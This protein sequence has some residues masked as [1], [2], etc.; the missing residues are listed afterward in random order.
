MPA[1]EAAAL[2]LTEPPAEQVQPARRPK[3]RVL[4]ITITFHPEPGAL[5]GLPLARRLVA[6]G[7]ADVTVLTAVPWYPLGRTYPGY[8]Q[9][10]WQWE[11]IDGVRI[12][13]VPIYP[14]HDSSAVRR[15]CTYLSF[16]ITAMTIGIPLAGR[17]DVVYHV[18]NL[19]T[20]GLVALLYGWLRGAPVVQ[21]VGDL[22]PESVTESGMLP[23]N[24]L[25]RFIAGALT[26]LCAFVYRRNAHI[27]VLSAGFERNLLARGL[28]RERVEV[29]HNWA[30]EERFHP[31]PPDPHL[32]EQLGMAG[33]FNV[34]YAGNIGP[35]QAIET[36]VRA[37]ALIRDLPG[38][39]I[40]IIG[41]GPR[42]SAVRALADELGTTNVCFLG[43]RPL[44]EMN[45][46]NAL[47][48]VLLVH[49]ADREFLRSTV[50]SKFQVAL[51]SAKPILLGVR[52]DAADLLRDAAAGVAFAPEN[53]EELA[54][55]IRALAM[56]PR[57]ELIAM[58]QRGKAYYDRSLSADQG[59]R[60]M[61]EIFRATVS[62]T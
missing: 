11:V 56:L 20:T 36:V 26:K 34:V 60:R 49:L 8:R 47:S 18:D 42:M 37:G 61:A 57:D 32:A 14:S 6:A 33:Y 48:D 28:S 41:D 24:G 31:T 50:P 27:T 52:G 45:D 21:H 35:L 13:R 2:T 40:V 58:G 15:I 5:R 59:H 30:E 25:G 9:R 19:P 53:E 16:M 1:P 12:L 43:R 46:I 7:D 54:G 51:A 4:F 39:Q 55:A 22:W 10:L 23:R 17:A 38:V 62:G 3:L 29:L 44:E